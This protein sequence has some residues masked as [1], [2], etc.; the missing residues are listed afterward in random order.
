MSETFIIYGVFKKTTFLTLVNS[1]KDF[2][3]RAK[4]FLEECD[5]IFSVLV[6][7]KSHAAETDTVIS[8]RPLTKP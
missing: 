5:N 6:I 2:A 7:G 8:L 3:K 4:L 1:G